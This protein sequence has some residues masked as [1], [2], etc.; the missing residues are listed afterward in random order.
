MVLTVRH[1]R[2]QVMR[3]LRTNMDPFEVVIEILV[4]IAGPWTIIKSTAT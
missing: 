1:I 2:R 4:V 3:F